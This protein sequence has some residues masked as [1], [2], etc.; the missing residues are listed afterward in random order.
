LLCGLGSLWEMSVDLMNGRKEQEKLPYRSNCRKQSQNAVADTLPFS[1]WGCSQQVSERRTTGQSMMRW[2][3]RITVS[4]ASLLQPISEGQLCA[5]GAA[6]TVGCPASPAPW[7]AHSMHRRAGM[8]TWVGEG[9]HL[10]TELRRIHDLAF[11][12]CEHEINPQHS[13]SAAGKFVL[14]EPGAVTQGQSSP[15]SGSAGN[16]ACSGFSM[17]HSFRF[18]ILLPKFPTAVFLFSGL[19]QL[20]DTCTVPSFAGRFFFYFLF[21]VIFLTFLHNLKQKTSRLKIQG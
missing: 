16:G 14:P 8:E 17:C 6:H 5:V 20:A 3:F 19:L 4:V 9:L 13:F 12:Q 15:F 7:E 11:Q 2:K 21:V 10:T 18:S 1:G